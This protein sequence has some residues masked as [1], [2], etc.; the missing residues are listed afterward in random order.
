MLSNSKYRSTRITYSSRWTLGGKIAF[1]RVI[2][3]L[4][5]ESY[6]ALRNTKTPAFICQNSALPF[7]TRVI[8]VSGQVWWEPGSRW[9][10]H[11]TK[12]QQLRCHGSPG[13]NS[14]FNFYWS[15]NTQP[16]KI[17]NSGSSG[18]WSSPLCSQNH[19]NTPGVTPCFYKWLVALS[20]ERE[21]GAEK[22]RGILLSICPTAPFRN[23]DTGEKK[24]PGCGFSNLRGK[25]ILQPSSSSSEGFLFFFFPPAHRH[26]SWQQDFVFW[27]RSRTCLCPRHMSSIQAHWSFHHLK[28]PQCCSQFEAAEKTA[29]LW[30]FL[31]NNHWNKQLQWHTGVGWR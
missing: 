4:K 25:S 17:R 5:N 16:C 13:K 31:W 7:L 28:T 30:H 23:R 22:S 21:K 11:F 12:Q 9:W 24:N 26:S 1:A 29:L 3:L 2:F 14:S 10:G 18:C 6:Y 20:S 19:S 8:S 15:Q 27:W